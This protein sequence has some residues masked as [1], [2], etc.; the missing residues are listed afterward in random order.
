MKLLCPR[1]LLGLASAG[2]RGEAEVSRRQGGPMSTSGKE[3]RQQRML[4]ILRQNGKAS[5]GELGEL[6]D[7]T[8]MTIRRDLEILEAAGAL[9]RYHGGAALVVGSSYEPPFSARERMNADA[10]RAIARSVTSLISDGDTLILDGGS[11]GLAVAQALFDRAVTVCPLSLRAA[12]CLAGSRSIRLLVP[13]GAIRHGERTFVGGETTEY[14]HRYNFDHYVLTASGLSVH[15]G[16][17]EWNPDDAAVKRVA[18]TAVENVIAAVD[19]TK[20][21]QVGFARVCSIEKPDLIVTDATIAQADLV[22]L[23]SH[24]RQIVVADGASPMP[25]EGSSGR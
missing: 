21:G 6:L 22:E 7:V 19:A 10:K 11:T 24:C 25:A 16:V 3:L 17:T 5:V 20:V 14:L 1:Q 23:D 15:G 8:E 12:W 4:E 18:L 9:K 2:G 13:G